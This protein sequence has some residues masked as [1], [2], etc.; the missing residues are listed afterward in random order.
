M[1]FPRLIHYNLYGKSFKEIRQSDRRT[2][3]V[4]VILF[5]CI[6]G[7]MDVLIFMGQSNMQG[8]TGELCTEPPAN[9]V[10]EYRY[11][12][13]ETVPLVSPVGEELGDGLLAASALGN[14]SLVPYFCNAYAKK[15]ACEIV[16]VHAA[17]GNTNIDEWQN[18]SE[19]FQVAVDKIV[20]GLKKAKKADRVF[21]V[22]L[23]GESDALRFLPKEEYKKKLIA[24]KNDLKKHFSFDKF[25]IIRTGYFA[26]YADW[27]PGTFREKEAADE[28]IMAAQE[29]VAKEY[30]EF[31]VL[32]DITKQLSV[33]TR[34]LNPKEYG[35]HYNNAGMKI[36]GNEA[37]SALAEIRRHL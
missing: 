22:W 25:C 23:Q 10:Y 5:E 27:I 13:N 4:A 35:P 8:S 16:A 30:E 12:T 19:R 7:K 33:D 9:G 26:A 29:E 2:E 32:T 21:I 34:F 28:Q 1:T 6:K 18:G 14:G 24:L 20:S 31:V 36:I 17:K 11:L 15:V 3:A 37:G